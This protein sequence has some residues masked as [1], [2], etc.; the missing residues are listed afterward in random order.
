MKNRCFFIKGEDFFYFNRNKI[1]L[2]INIKI[3]K[4]EESFYKGLIYFFNISRMKEVFY[5]FFFYK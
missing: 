2:S 3:G 4:I 5:L 1:N